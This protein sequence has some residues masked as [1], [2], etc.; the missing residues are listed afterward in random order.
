MRNVVEE[1]LRGGSNDRHDV[2]AGERGGFGLGGI[3]VDVA[4]R[5]DDVFE[6][7]ERGGEFG[8][9]GFAGVARGVDV[10]DCFAGALL[11]RLAHLGQ[12]WSARSAIELRTVGEP[13]GCFVDRSSA[14]EKRATQIEGDAARQ[15]PILPVP[16][17]EEVDQRGA[18]VVDAFHT[19]GP[20]SR[21]FDAYR[22]VRIDEPLDLV[23]DLRGEAS[24]RS[25]HTLIDRY[26]GHPQ[27]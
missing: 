27:V 12:P 7:R 4:G 5:D 15:K 1:R 18:L 24:A 13:F 8:F 16:I 10:V 11:Q 22:G 2:G 14:G 20:R 25:N 17:D 3:V 19:V 6:R 26:L 23:G 9:L 21:A